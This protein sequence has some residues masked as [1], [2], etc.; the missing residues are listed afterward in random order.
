M[1]HFVDN[2]YAEIVFMVMKSK[3]AISYAAIMIDQL[4]PVFLCVE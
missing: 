4:T 3:P 2:H 1:D